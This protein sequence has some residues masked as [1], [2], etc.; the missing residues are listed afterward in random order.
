MLRRHIKIGLGG[1]H[2]VEYCL[3][4]V[5]F[6]R[7]QIQTKWSPTLTEATVE[8]GLRIGSLSLSA[9]RTYRRWYDAQRPSLEPAT[10][11]GWR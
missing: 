11:G 4:G 1:N 2:Y 6:F 5:W 3:L 7:R 10:D 8:R 9:A